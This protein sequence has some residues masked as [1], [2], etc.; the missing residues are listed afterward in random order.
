MSNYLTDDYT[1]TNNDILKARQR[2]AGSSEVD[3]SCNK[4]QWTFIDLGGQLSE[5]E[6]WSQYL[7]GNTSQNKKPKSFIAFLAMDEFDRTSVEDSTKSKLMFALDV[8]L[9]FA[10]IPEVQNLTPI[11]VLNKF[12]VFTS[13]ISTKQGF[14][15]F[16]KCFPKF[17][18]E[19]KDEESA[20]KYL[21]EFV[22]G[23][24]EQIAMIQFRSKSRAH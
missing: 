15:N 22:R 14:S 17:S 1:F 16:Q 19:E 2:T 24:L 13:K 9:K 10:E 5:R 21:Q 18:S 23:K 6:K 8:I 12:D 11:V 4:N 3:L 20:S 7:S